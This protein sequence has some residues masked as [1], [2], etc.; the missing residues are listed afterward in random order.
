MAKDKLVTI[1][2]EGWKR[3]QLNQYC[4]DKGTRVSELITAYIDKCLLGIIDIEPNIDKP[5]D[6]RYETLT[7][8][9]NQIEELTT[10]NIEAILIRLDSI[11]TRLDQPQKAIEPQKDPIVTDRSNG[12]SHSQLSKII[13]RD[14]STIS[15]W[16][17]GKRP[18][19]EDI[20]AAWVYDGVRWHSIP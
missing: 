5:I 18:I 20:A 13:G 6:D 12:L 16:S 10:Q 15:R 19:P 9:Y 3:D 17:T 11:E 7:S 8:R 4:Q 2:I 14:K 1:P